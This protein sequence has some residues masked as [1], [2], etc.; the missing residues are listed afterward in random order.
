VIALVAATAHGGAWTK[1]VGEVYTK[2]GAEVYHAFT[3]VAPGTALLD[4]EGDYFGQQYSVYAE[5]GVLPGYKGQLL[6]KVPLVVGVHGAEYSDALGT[7]PLRATTTRPG[8]LELGAQVALHPELPISAAVLAKIPLYANGKV[9]QD[10]P[11]FAALFPKPGDGQVD[12]TGVV[13]AGGS[14]IPKSFGEV[15]LGYR[16]RTEWF[17]GWDT[18]VTYVDGVVFVAK[19]GYSLGRVLPIVSVDGLKSV[20]DDTYS[21]EYVTL[22]GSALIDVAEGL[23]IEPRIAAELWARKSSR[24]IGGGIGVSYRR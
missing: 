13:Y 11:T 2:A 9:G 1:E 4:E 3:F 12:L 24:G 14:P 7:V 21:R 17:T 16:H 22:S 8:D 18:S 23:A 10:Y 15:G 19:G 5:A 6:V 20:K